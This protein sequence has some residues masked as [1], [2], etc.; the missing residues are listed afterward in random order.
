[1]SQRSVIVERYRSI[2][3][4]PN[5]DHDVR[6]YYLNRYIDKYH[7]IL[8]QEC[9]SKSIL[10][11]SLRQ[12]Y[13]PTFMD[14][15]IIY[16]DYSCNDLMWMLEYYQMECPLELL[17]ETKYFYYH[18]DYM[19]MVPD[20]HIVKYNHVIASKTLS[21][22]REI[23]ELWKQRGV[24]YD[25]VEVSCEEMEIHVD[26]LDFLNSLNVVYDQR[27]VNVAKYMNNK[28]TIEELNFSEI[29]FLE[30]CGFYCRTNIIDDYLNLI[31]GNIEQGLLISICR[32][33]S[34][35]DKVSPNVWTA[36]FLD[37]ICEIWSEN[38][39]HYL[40][41]IVYLLRHKMIVAENLTPPSHDDIFN[42]ILI[43]SRID[44]QIIIELYEYTHHLWHE[45]FREYLLSCCTLMSCSNKLKNTIFHYLQILIRLHKDYPCDPN[46]ED[47]KPVIELLES[48]HLIPKDTKHSLHS[49]C[50]RGDI[51]QV[52]KLCSKKRRM[53]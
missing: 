28:I 33:I 15:N 53:K 31:H 22:P 47:H 19:H 5:I 11:R 2:K 10:I 14:A 6:N 12:G 25:Q 50:V 36:D 30:N 1:M 7:N 48:F 43:N 29:E 24:C 39:D 37:E 40:V 44:S 26:E 52:K 38:Q 42:M 34:S 51:E 17:E 35:F 4:L 8:M 49:V 45:W 13:Q 23:I 18:S 46:N 16:S 9:P 41:M 32:Y 20:D 21:E 27:L 3:H